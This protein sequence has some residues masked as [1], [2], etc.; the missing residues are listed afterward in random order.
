MLE[1][2]QHPAF[3]ELHYRAA[4]KPTADAFYID[5]LELNSIHTTELIRVIQRKN[6]MAQSLRLGA[7]LVILAVIIVFTTG[8]ALL[9]AGNLYGVPLVCIVP[10]SFALYQVYVLQMG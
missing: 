4:K 5:M 8:I 10:A 9:F 2:Y 6:R 1:R 7:K 3:E